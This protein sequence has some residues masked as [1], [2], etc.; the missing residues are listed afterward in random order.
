MAAYGLEHIDL[1]KIDIEGAEKEVFRDASAWIDN[2]RMLVVELHE[3]VAIGCSRVF[4][5]ATGNF[6]V[7]W[8]KGENVYLARSGTC[9]PPP[10]ADVRR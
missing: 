10:G 9:P 8:C 3:F 7:E 4:Y 2:V 5:A 6:E 1:L